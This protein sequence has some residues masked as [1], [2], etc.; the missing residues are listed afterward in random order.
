MGSP[1]RGD[2]ACAFAVEM[3]RGIVD[4]QSVFRI[5]CRPWCQHTMT[6]AVVSSSET[7]S[8]GLFGCLS[9]E[10]I[11]LMCVTQHLCCQVCIWADALRH[12]GMNDRT[13]TALGMTGL[14]SVSGFWGRR[15]IVQRYGLHES[16]R[17]SAC[18]STL[19]GPCARCQEINTV[20]SRETLRYGCT[21]L[22]RNGAA[23]APRPQSISR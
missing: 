15:Y 20:M 19:C 18:Y 23:N 17:A 22:R 4:Y 10:D 6:Q 8:T 16:E 7:W 9:G 3:L 2:C 11:G 21:V 12:V 5:P 13:A 1:N 14:H